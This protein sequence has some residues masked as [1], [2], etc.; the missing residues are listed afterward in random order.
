MFDINDFDETLPRAVRVGPQAARGE[1]RGRRPLAWLPRARRPSSR[2]PRGPLV[3]DADGRVRGHARDR[4][5]LRAGRRRRHPRLRRQAGPTVP[6]GDGPRRPPPRRAARA[7]QADRGGSDGKRRIVDRPAGHHPS[8][9]RRRRS[10]IDDALAGYRDDASRRT[11]A[12]CSTGTRWSTSRS[13]S[14]ASG[15]SVSAPSPSLLDG[16]RRR[17]PAV[18]PG[19]AGRGIGA[20]AVPSRPSASR[21]TA[22]GSSSGQRRLQAAS[23]VLLGWTVGDRGRHWYVR[24]LQDQKGGAVVEAMT[25]DDLAAWGELC[26]WAL[27]RG[28]AR[29]ASRPTIAGYLGEDDAFDH[30]LAGSPTPTP[31]RPSGTTRR[32]WPPSPQGASPLPGNWD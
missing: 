1:H 31:T 4:R 29:S 7:A 5:L 18:P 8:G 15:A 2:P 16:R 19:Q 20:R 17:R 30:A 13:R 26:G 10:A 9:R 22:P 23:D 24:Q 11:G 32:C 3:P 12:S 28:H 21:A 25:L 14:S 6:R 27:A